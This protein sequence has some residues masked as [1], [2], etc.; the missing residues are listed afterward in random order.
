VYLYIQ[1]NYTHYTHI[2]NVNTNFYF[3]CDAQ[4]LYM[5]VCVY[6]C[7]FSLCLLCADMQFSNTVAKHA[8]RDPFW[9]VFFNTGIHDGDLVC[10]PFCF[11]FHPVFS[12]NVVDSMMCPVP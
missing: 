8:L 11:P 12:S 4:A 1:N 5:R 6:I 3:G 7:L 9:T 2:Y 10:Q